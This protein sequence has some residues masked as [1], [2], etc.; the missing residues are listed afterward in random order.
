MRVGGV[1]RSGTASHR[2][3]FCAASQQ[4]RRMPPSPWIACSSTSEVLRAYRLHIRPGDRVLEF[5]A[6]LRES[7]EA[8]VSLARSPRQSAKVL[9]LDIVR[10]APRTDSEHTKGC[11]RS[12]VSVGSFVELRSLQEWPRAVRNH[13]HFDVISID[14]PVITGNDLLVDTLALLQQL[15]SRQSAPPRAVIIKSNALTTLSWQLHHA[16]R[17]L[18]GSVSL[19]ESP[20]PTAHSARTS[21][22]TDPP[23]PII[24]AAVGVAQ[25][26]QTIPL[27][28]CPGDSVIELGCHSGTTTALLH[29]TCTAQ[30][31]G[32]ATGVDNSHAIVNAARERHPGVKFAVADAWHT[33]KLARLSQQETG[34]RKRA[35]DAVYVDVGGLSGPDGLL[36]AVS[37]LNG[38]AMALEPRCIVIKSACMR[39]LASSLRPM[40]PCANSAVVD[41]ERAR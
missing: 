23:L 36:S 35:Y 7:S 27:L 8:I 20:T 10:K 21:L 4:R 13:D 40:A 6:Q 38:L 30:G 33:G 15:V 25:Y 26:R 1:V 19:P 29:A 11:R 12:N 17:L 37:L 28:V 24:V 39:R 31:G 41:K 18:D 32:S 16:S 34:T 9:Q 22:A 14:L 2:R 5:G 3:S